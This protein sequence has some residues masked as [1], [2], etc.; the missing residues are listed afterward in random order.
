MSI[1]NRDRGYT[2]GIAR[3]LLGSIHKGC[4]HLEGGTG[5]SNNAYQNGLN[6]INNFFQSSCICPYILQVSLKKHLYLAGLP[7]IIPKKAESDSMNNAVSVR[8]EFWV[9]PCSKMVEDSWDFLNL[10][11]Y[12]FKHASKHLLGNFYPS[13]LSMSAIHSN[14]PCVF[15]IQRNKG[16][17]SGKSIFQIWQTPW[18]N[19]C[20]FFRVSIR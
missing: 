8:E 2:I 13:I 9:S 11:T 20:S 19:L 6:A 1:D 15:K 18:N 5:V 10:H 7:V 14:Y 3:G 12:P 17:F 16:Y 4:P